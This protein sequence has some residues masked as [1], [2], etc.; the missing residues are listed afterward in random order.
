M[1]LAKSLAVLLHRLCHRRHMLWAVMLR[2][3]TQRLLL[4]GSQ[5]LHGSMAPLVGKII[6][7]RG[8]GKKSE[9]G[10]AGTAKT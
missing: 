10:V 2:V 3:S 9:G 7:Y 1:G 6:D 4:S 5:F 8:R